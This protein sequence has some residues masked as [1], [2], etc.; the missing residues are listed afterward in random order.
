MKLGGPEEIVVDVGYDGQ[1]VFAG[2]LLQRRQYVRGG[3]SRCPRDV[4][5]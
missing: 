5:I 3:L 1:P 4:H 2:Q